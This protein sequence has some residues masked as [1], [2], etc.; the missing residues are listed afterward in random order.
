MD[1]KDKEKSSSVAAFEK[2]A[3]QFESD[4]IIEPAQRGHGPLK[5][6]LKNRHVAMISLAG[7]IGVGIFVNTATALRSGGPIGLVLGFMTM[8]VVCW[9]VMISLG[10]MVSYLPL[11]GGH[12]RLAERF[13]NKALSFAMGWNYWYNWVIILPAELS[14]AAI[15]IDY[16]GMRKDAVWITVCLIVVITINMLGAGVYG[17]CEFVFASIKILT[18]VGLII[19]GIILD[20]G[21]GP[22]HDRIGFRY[23]K[24]P[25]PFVQYL[26]IE[27]AKGRFLGYWSV[28]TTAAFSFIGTEIVAIAAGEAKNPRRNVPRAIRRVY[29]RIIFFYFTSVIIIS[30]LVPSNHPLLN[31]KSK[32]ASA[33]PFVIAIREAGI[34]GLPGFINACLLT[35]AWSA[36]SS[37]LYTSSRALYGMALTGNAP[38]VFSRTSRNGLPYVSV[39]FCAAFCGLAYMGVSSGSGKV[40]GW[41]ANLTSICGMITWTGICFT[42][43][44]FYAGLKAQGIDR[45]TLPYYSMCQP[46][47]AW[48]G[49]ISTLIICFFSGWTVFLK[50]S[51]QTDTFLTNYLPL[52]LFPVIYIGARFYY[53]E[54][55]VRPEN[56][57]FKSNI[58]E[59]EADEAPEDPPKNMLESIWRWLVSLHSLTE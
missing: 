41:L 6:Q 14:A 2:P 43:L 51:W 19:L 35:S 15:L 28:L 52:M 58:A 47:A 37:D 59:I 53:K 54:P 49:I 20:L 34:K 4:D 46:Y 21:G 24:E 16:W 5:R 18:L 56:M 7:V 25:G 33:S 11:P 26:G 17:E 22:S 31:F 13:G 57:D 44:R 23:W 40:F 45:K 29:V 50:N 32:D 8:G 30:L 39:I 27:G 1:F 42:Y 55:L 38:K 9:S 10:E 12:I 48:F 36:A 3:G